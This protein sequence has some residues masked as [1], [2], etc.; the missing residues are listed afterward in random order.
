MIVG[1]VAPPT[2]SVASDCGVHTYS[3][4]G[5]SGSATGWIVRV[6]AS[7]R[8]CVACAATSTSSSSARFRS[9]MPRCSGR[10]RLA[11][12]RASLI[13]SICCCVTPEHCWGTVCSLWLLSSAALTCQ[14][15]V[16]SSCWVWKS[17]WLTPALHD[18]PFQRMVPFCT[19]YTVWSARRASSET[20][21]GCLPGWPDA[22]YQ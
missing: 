7:G 14:L 6:A 21:R 2:S 17:M 8:R 16:F 9:S 12:C 10:G 5:I 3:G 11:P 20:T 22:P 19:M 1:A 18:R 4:Y 15:G 13:Y